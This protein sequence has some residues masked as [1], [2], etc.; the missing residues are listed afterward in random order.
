MRVTTFTFLLLALAGA[1]S[2]VRHCKTDEDCKRN[3]YCMNDPSKTPPYVCHRRVG[4]N[5]PVTAA[6]AEEDLDVTLPSGLTGA[7]N[8]A[9]SQ[10]EKDEK[11]A[12][13]ALN[14]YTGVVHAVMI[15]VG[16]L[17]ALFGYRL[18]G[19]TIFLAGAAAAGYSSY[20]LASAYPQDADGQPTAYKGK[21]Y[22]VTIVPIVLALI[23]GT[24][25][26]KLRKV[27]VFLAGAAGGVVGALA[28]NT[29]VLRKIPQTTWMQNNVPALY[30]IIAAVVL[31]LIG[32]ILALKLER[33]V[34]VISTSIC[35]SFA[36][37]WGVGYWASGTNFLSVFDSFIKDPTAPVVSLSPS[38]AP[39]NPQVSHDIMYAYLGAF[40]IC[41]FISTF[42]QFRYTAKKKTKKEQDQN[43]S[44]LPY[45]AESTK[46]STNNASDIAGYGY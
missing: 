10:A 31:G 25:V 46:Y 37:T 41:S 22:V 23:F 11:A 30:M 20:L 27:G 44:L 12:E 17:V 5:A 15:P 2:A 6:A 16:L 13:A 21:I 3:S 43:Q 45:D 38:A 40:V 19:P 8:Q 32:G 7:A 36:T 34:L 28:L 24:V 4:L 1:A 42:V 14:K 39:S 29:A 35:G 26:Y 9:K 18:V 33:F